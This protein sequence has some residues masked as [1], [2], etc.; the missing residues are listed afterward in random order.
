MSAIIFDKWIGIEIYQTSSKVG[1]AWTEQDYRIR[2]PL[3]FF[4]EKYF[5]VYVLYTIPAF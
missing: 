4:I 1:I 2:L 3:P 5:I